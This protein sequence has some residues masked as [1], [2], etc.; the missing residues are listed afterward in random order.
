MSAVVVWPRGGKNEGVK[1]VILIARTVG[2]IGS[3]QLKGAEKTEANRTWMLPGS[4]V[5]F[6]AGNLD[7]SDFISNFVSKK[8]CNISVLYGYGEIL[9]EFKKS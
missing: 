3:M 4:I 9:C 1:H 2:S 5:G 6:L 8:N 7:Y